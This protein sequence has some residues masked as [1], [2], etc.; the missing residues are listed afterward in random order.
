MMGAKKPGLT[1]L[2]RESADDSDSGASV[3]LA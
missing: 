1:G 2:A 3:T